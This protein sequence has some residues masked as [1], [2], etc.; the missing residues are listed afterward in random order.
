MIDTQKLKQFYDDLRSV[1]AI[2]RGWFR[3]HQ[4]QDKVFFSGIGVGHAQEGFPAEASFDLAAEKGAFVCFMTTEL[5]LI[6]CGVAGDKAKAVV[7]SALKEMIN[8]IPDKWRL[9]ASN[10]QYL[11]EIEKA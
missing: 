9:I 3:I 5:E 11:E 6:R 8:P 10:R 2:K 1:T 7:V 4:H